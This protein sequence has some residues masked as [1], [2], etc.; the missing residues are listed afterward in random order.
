MF[1]NETMAIWFP[2]AELFGIYKHE[3]ATGDPDIQAG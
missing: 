1:L 2:P 3:E